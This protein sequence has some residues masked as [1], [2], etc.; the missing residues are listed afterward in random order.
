[1]ELDKW[2]RERGSHENSLRGLD[3][4]STG[5]SAESLRSLVLPE[6]KAQSRDV[7][8]RKEAEAWKRFVNDGI[9]EEENEF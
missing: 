9:K 2:R 4:H 6:W 7:K 5:V 8:V 1:M 3:L